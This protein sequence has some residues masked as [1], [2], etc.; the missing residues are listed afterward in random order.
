MRRGQWSRKCNRDQRCGGKIK[1]VILAICFFGLL[2]GCGSEPFQVDEG[3]F[4]GVAADEP[5]AALIMRDILVEGGKAADAAVAGYFA[6]SV[7]LP[8]SA[9]LSAAGSC[10][11]FD[12]EAKRYEQLDFQAQPASDMTNAVSLPIAPRAMFALHARYGAIRFERLIVE[13]EKLARFGERVSSRL[14]TDL[15]WLNPANIDDTALSVILRREDGQALVKGDVLEQ[16]D[17]AGSLARLRRDGVGDLYVGQL[18]RMFIE[19]SS[20]VGVQID[21][22]RLRDALPVW[23]E[24]GLFVHDNHDWGVVGSDPRLAR[25]AS[26]L[27]AGLLGEGAWGDMDT[28]ARIKRLSSDEQFGV[29]EIAGRPT[30]PGATS[31]LVVDRHGQAVAC[32]LGMGH[33]FG[34][35]LTA[36]NT[37]VILRPAVDNGASAA[38]ATIAGN[39]N[40]WQVHLGATAG[41]GYAAIGA[42]I[43]PLLGHYDVGASVP[44]AV[45]AARAIASTDKKTV[46]VEPELSKSARLSIDVAQLTEVPAIGYANLFRCV[47]GIPRESESCDMVGD[48]RGGGLAVFERE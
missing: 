9:G 29:R 2:A 26:A 32:A 43:Y 31:F 40:A 30:V 46:Y 18:A 44:T 20:A 14:A 24:A 1:S 48:R 28:A 11:V 19:G 6:L 33:P 5:R 37:G 10:L 36:A 8:S 34:L 25:K 12:P 45:A 21:V 7:T 39:R 22:N 38:F 47:G 13:A 35:V 42:L 3:F 41:G 27:L 4:G 16:S 15:Q 17:L 23:S